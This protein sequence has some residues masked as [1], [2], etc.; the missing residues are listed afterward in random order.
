MRRLLP[1]VLLAGACAAVSDRASFED[2]AARPFESAVTDLAFT[3]DGTAMVAGLDDG[4]L[5]VLDAHTIR[6]DRE[7]RGPDTDTELVTRTWIAPRADAAAWL[8]ESPETSELRV[9]DCG[10]GRSRRRTASDANERVTAVAFDPEGLRVVVGSDVGVARAAPIAHG[11]W[12][13]CRIAGSESCTG[14]IVAMAFDDR[15]M[16]WARGAWRELCV[17]VGTFAP[18]ALAAGSR[19][20]T[21]D[22][23]SSSLAPASSAGAASNLRVADVLAL[24]STTAGL[25]LVARVARDDTDL[26]AWRAPTDGATIRWEGE[27]VILSRSSHA[28]THV[29]VSPDGSRVV[30]QG[31]DGRCDV[32]ELVD[33]RRAF[34]FALDE[35]AFDASGDYLGG[36]DGS[37][38]AVVIDAHDGATI[39]RLEVPRPD[40][41]SAVALDAGA[42]RLAA[43]TEFGVVHV[44]AL[45]H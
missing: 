15:G 38:A 4:R 30:V 39:E 24:E 45:A 23:G 33:G 7:L 6:V 11:A 31:A 29:R 40:A 43:G 9:V 35:F 14:P 19:G 32:H 37:G 8:V 12:S 44:W 2:R 17:E 28:V 36:I 21:T 41:V 26:R 20:G 18:G 1:C 25:V 16:A 13:P 27:G 10:S 5:V 3:R 34:G 42:R 22:P